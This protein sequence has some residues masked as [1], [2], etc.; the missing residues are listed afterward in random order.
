MVMKLG[1][2]RGVGLIHTASLVA[3]LLTRSGGMVVRCHPQSQGIHPLHAQDT[4]TFK[5]QLELGLRASFPWFY[6]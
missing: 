6:A 5:P 1:I 2:R 3:Q 4:S